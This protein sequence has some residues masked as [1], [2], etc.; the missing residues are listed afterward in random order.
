MRIDPIAC[1]SM[2]WWIMIFHIQSQPV[3]YAYF[4][5]HMLEWEHMPG[6]S[7]RFK[8]YKCPYLRIA[9]SAFVGNRDMKSS[10]IGKIKLVLGIH[11]IYHYL[12]IYPLS[13][14]KSCV[15][16]LPYNY[17]L[18]FLVFTRWLTIGWAINLSRCTICK[19]HPASLC[20]AKHIIGYLKLPI[21]IV[22]IPSYHSIFW[23]VY[24]PYCI[25]LTI[26]QLLSPTAYVHGIY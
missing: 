23:L 9:V 2:S 7:E 15:D 14:E 16:K 5:T 11:I 8:W 21:H 4:Q 26:A 20:K 10:S 22:N 13:H 12:S 17:N 25:I 1:D 3:E 18:M 24:C 6:G 19:Q